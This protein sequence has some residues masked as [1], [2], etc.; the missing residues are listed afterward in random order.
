MDGETVVSMVTCF[1][2]EAM[3]AKD[4]ELAL[5]SNER[6]SICLKS[7]TQLNC[8][9]NMKPGEKF[10]ARKTQENSLSAD[11]ALEKKSNESL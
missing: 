7:S 10:V 9:S 5:P 1:W 3:Q 4:K 2:S 11:T 8:L 6:K